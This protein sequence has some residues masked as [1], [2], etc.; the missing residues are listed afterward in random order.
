[1]SNS[2][3]C[4]PL[5]AL[6]LELGA[7][8]VEFA[9]YAMPV[10]YPHGI[11]YEHAHTRTSAGLFDISH[12]GQIRVSGQQAPGLMES[13]VPGD[14][15]GLEANRQL[16]TV[17]T[18]A[19]GGV[20]DDLMITNLV[21]ELFLVVNAAR[22]E[23][24]LALL[25]TAMGRNC[26]VDYCHE[27]AL[28]A[29]QGPLAQSVLEEYLPTVNSL[30]FMQAGHCKIDGIDCL[31]HRCGY[32]GED[33]F[34]ISIDNKDAEQLARLL[35]QHAAVEP[36]GLGAR[37]SLRLEA[38]LCLYG[39][40][41]DETTSPVEAG[42]G[43][44]VAKKY[45]DGQPV[46]ARFPGAERIL[47]QLQ[48]GTAML[49][50]GIKPEGRMPVR[51]GVELLHPSGARAGRITS[52]GFGTTVNGPIAMAYVKSEYAVPGTLMHVNIRGRSHA[53]YTAA[54]PFVTHRYHKITRGSMNE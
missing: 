34:E 18:N 20:I 1:M 19:D 8:M 29:L 11:R 49:R 41:L 9:G 42:L 7:R 13:L 14:V 28:L 30:E 15:T 40:D 23:T 48:Q 24:D 54:L 43:W 51:E 46:A 45:R 31:I 44:V 6:H 2:I 12:M 50:T 26:R 32:T 4:T 27:R 16:Y 39:H 36:A 25:Q 10:Q 37:D 3:N 22:R 33:G 17:F 52:G 53:V 38:G 21:D 5:R 47:V 35:L